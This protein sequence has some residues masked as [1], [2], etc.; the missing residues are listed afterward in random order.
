MLVNLNPYSAE[1]VA[2]TVAHLPK[3]DLHVLAETFGR[4]M[5]VV[6]RRR[7]LAPYTHDSVMER[8]REEMPAGLGRLLE[9]NRLIRAQ[10]DSCVGRDCRELYEQPDF[11]EACFQHLLEEEAINGSLLAEVRLGGV[12]VFYPHLLQCFRS[13]ESRVQARHP[14]FI[15]EPLIAWGLEAPETMEKVIR[16][17]CELAAEGLRGVDLYPEYIRFDY[18][19][20]NRMAEIAVDAGLGVTCHAGEF[21]SAGLAEALEI[22]GLTRLGHATQSHRDIARLEEIARRGIVVEVSLTS[23]VV[24]GAVNTYEEHP[25]RQFLDAGVRV[26]LCSDDPITFATDIGREYAFARK[27]GFSEQELLSC[28]LTGVEAS[29]ASAERKRTLIDFLA[30][31]KAEQVHSAS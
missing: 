24:L 15:A 13:A 6:E 28:A 3:T 30:S 23:N 25:L 31:F 14:L 18:P 4:L 12:W 11:V 2:D 26:T 8:L 16:H 29:F 22:P 1:I 7:G 19:A 10:A 5:R 17:T 27:L 9:A 20:I 21:A